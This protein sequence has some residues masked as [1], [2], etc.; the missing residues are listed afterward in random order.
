MTD[1]A[2]TIRALADFIEK[3]GNS[4]WRQF[5]VFGFFAVALYTTYENRAQVWLNLLN[6]PY[7]AGSLG[8]G[9]LLIFIGWGI[10]GLQKRIYDRY[11]RE[12][13]DK[14]NRINALE[15]ALVRKDEQVLT[16]REDIRD[17][18]IRIEEKLED[19]R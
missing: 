1:K 11:D 7:L 15:A 3:V 14:A 13:D 19:L 4:K 8:V 16:I 5:L 9:A 17:R 12:L 10:T 2:D 18:L 6:S